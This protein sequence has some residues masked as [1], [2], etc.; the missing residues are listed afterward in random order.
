M[1][2]LSVSNA[3]VSIEGYQQELVASCEY[4]V[5]NRPQELD[6]P[7]GAYF[8]WPLR[9]GTLSFSYYVNPDAGN[10]PYVESGDVTPVPVTITIRAAGKT[11]VISE[12]YRT[13]VTIQTTK[14]QEMPIFQASQTYT[15]LVDNPSDGDY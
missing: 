15:T 13:G 5:D 10:L 12:A 4:S 3:N 11:I 8:I 9:R 7:S 14:L 2:V 6:L 1:K